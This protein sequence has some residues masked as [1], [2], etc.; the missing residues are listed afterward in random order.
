M[1][2]IES[3]LGFRLMAFSYKFRD[4][5]LPRLNILKEVG[6]KTVDFSSLPNEGI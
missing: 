1:D 3:N 6:I 2:K 5:R 4:L